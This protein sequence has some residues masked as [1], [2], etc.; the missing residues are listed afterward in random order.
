ME[1]PEQHNRR[2][3][4]EL[5]ARLDRLSANRCAPGVE[6]RAAEML[7]ALVGSYSDTALRV[8]TDW[9]KQEARLATP[10]APGEK[11]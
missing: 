3:F 4:P 8:A 9:L 1:T 11:A 10:T 7:T 5:M 6:E 2:K